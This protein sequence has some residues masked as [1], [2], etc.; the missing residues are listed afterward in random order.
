MKESILHAALFTPMSDGSWGLRIVLWGDPGTVKSSIIR[1]IAQR[2]GFHCEV[3][4]PGERGEGAFGVTPVPGEANGTTIM[5]YPAPE[6]VKNFRRNGSKEEAGIIFADELTTAPPALQPALLGLIQDGRLGGHT[7]GPRVRRIAAANAVEQAAGGWD[8]AAPVAN[9][10]GHI[11]WGAPKVSEW[12]DWMI[13]ANEQREPIDARKEEARVMQ[14]WPA[15]YAKAAGLASAFLSR[16]PNLFH[17]MPEDGSP[18]ASRAWP[19]AR[20]WEYAVRA[21]ASAE[22]H[23]LSDID[24]DEFVAAFIGLG[25][26]GEWETYIR[27]ADL[28]DPVKILDGQEEFVHE[29]DR[30]DRTWA[31]L[32]SCTGLVV[33]EKAEKRKARAKGLWNLVTEIM[34]DA[35]DVCVPTVKTLISAKLHTMP[36]AG[37]P[38]T[39]LHDM[40][41]A[42]GRIGTVAK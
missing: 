8:L 36:E 5:Q 27:E 23:G 21:R 6:W 35:K 26:S 29:D 11:S 40:L 42:A 34:K 16:R 20:S 13:G 38:M 39:R 2:L 14:A 12:S 15:A 18:D 30:L 32:A 1:A 37:P 10:L 19:S 41:K 28:P 24:T 33:P 25:P 17:K 9:R 3:L 31:V 7:F 4:C 22:V